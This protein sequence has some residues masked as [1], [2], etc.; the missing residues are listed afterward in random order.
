MNKKSLLCVLL[1]ALMVFGLCACGEKAP[2]DPNL[3]D[4]GKKTFE[5]YYKG[6]CIMYNE[7]GEDS[8]VVTFDFTN[9]SSDPI[10]YGWNVYD[11]AT[12]DGVE[13]ESTYV[14]VD[15]DTYASVSENYFT[16]VEPG[17]TLEVSNAFKLNGTG[18]VTL[19]IS[20]IWDKH[21]YDITIDPTTLERVDNS[22]PDSFGD[23]FW[24]DSS[25]D[26]ASGDDAAAGGD[27]ATAGDDTSSTDVEASATDPAT[28]E[29]ASFYADYWAGDW[30]GWWIVRNATGEFESYSGNWWDAC[31][32]IT[33][34]DDATGLIDIWD[35][36][37]S[38]TDLTAYS[39]VKFEQIEGCEHGCMI[40]ESG[41]FM[42]GAVEA[43]DWMVYP[44]AAN[45]E[46]MLIIEGKNS[47]DTGFYTYTVYLRP[48]GKVWDDVAE[49]DLPYQY[50]WYLEQINSGAIMPDTI[51]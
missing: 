33:V 37:G 7:S 35:D 11:K 40:S 16:D 41:E 51:G 42:G 47:T 25:S 2:K 14:V 1:A 29:L 4:F 13:L 18:V 17:A 15:W 36:A 5:L 19:N 12:Q 10:S 27:A 24:G 50:E 3:Y 49:E 6:A 34:Y 22:N 23:D 30:F 46:D 38:S 45:C 43:G 48:W 26:D 20:D 39:S 44:E 28:A 32:T 31:A 9:K 21:V 8:V